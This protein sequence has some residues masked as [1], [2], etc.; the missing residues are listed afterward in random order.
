ML[1]EHA[2]LRDLLSQLL[3]SPLQQI[4]LEGKL[5]GKKWLLKKING[6]FSLNDPM[7]PEFHR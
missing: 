5:T 1:G 7:L 6:S 2:L 4:L 3:S